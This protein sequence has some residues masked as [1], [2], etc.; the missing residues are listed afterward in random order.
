MS[1][2]KRLTQNKK[3]IMHILKVLTFLTYLST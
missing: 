3:K 2:S 1:Q